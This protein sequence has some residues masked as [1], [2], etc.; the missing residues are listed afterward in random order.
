MNMGWICL[1]RDILFHWIW[2]DK[3]FA[4]GQAWIDLLLKANYRENKFLLGNS[5]INAKKG[6]VVTSTVKL[7]EDWSWSRTKVTSFLKTLEV[8]EMITVKKDSKKTVINIVNYEV[9]QEFLN[10]F[11]KRKDSEK[12]TKNQQENIVNTAESQHQDNREISTEHQKDT[13]NKV[14]KDNKETKNPP[15]PPKGDADGFES[16]WQAYPRK[17]AKQAALKA[18]N[19]LKPDADLQQAILSALEQ[20]KRSVQWQK[21]GGQFIPYPATWLNGSRW[22]DAQE[23]AVQ[24]PQTPQI[25]QPPYDYDPDDPYKDWR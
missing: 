18:W 17:T 23:Q 19:K 4:K 16:F 21:D 20:Q 3:P 5:V 15:L 10:I 24:A 13:I 25:P 14:N 11:D 1:Q 22:E 7:A 12:T 9:Y 6:T 2:Q 8:D